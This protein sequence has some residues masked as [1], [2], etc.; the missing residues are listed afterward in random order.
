MFGYVVMNRPEIKF[1][2]YDLYRS[3]YCG[4]CRELRERYGISGQ[5]TLTYDMTFVILLL[6]G[7]YEPPTKKGTSRCMVHPVRKQPV[8]KNKVTEYAADMNVFLAYYKCVDDWK[9]EKKLSRLAYSRLLKNKDKK[10]EALWKKKTADII[11]HLNEISAM[12]KQ[13]KRILIKYLDALGKSW[14]RFLLERGRMGT[15]FKANGVLSGKI[16]LF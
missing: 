11:K 10:A 3:F 16:Y 4:L 9:D 8:R 7:L 6:S 15:C 12:E 13:E 5:I 14:R 2:D 1:K